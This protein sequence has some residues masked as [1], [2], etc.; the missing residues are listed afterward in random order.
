MHKNIK[1]PTDIMHSLKDEK[2]VFFLLIVV[3]LVD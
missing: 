1:I 3:D 2:Q